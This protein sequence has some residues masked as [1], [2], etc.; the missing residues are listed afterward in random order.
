MLLVVMVVR[1]VAVDIGVH[2]VTI[3]GGVVSGVAVQRVARVAME[4]EPDSVPELQ[5]QHDTL[6]L[7]LRN[8]VDCYAGVVIP[9]PVSHQQQTHDPV[10]QP[11]IGRNNPL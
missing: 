9:R 6:A 1:L 7:H 8:D 11:F 4:T 3:E 2:K 5:L 10:T